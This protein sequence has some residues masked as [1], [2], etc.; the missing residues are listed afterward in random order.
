MLPVM[1]EAIGRSQIF[2]HGVKQGEVRM[3]FPQG[4]GTRG[5]SG[6]V[7]C[8]G[9]QTKKNDLRDCSLPCS[10]GIPVSA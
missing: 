9:L 2:C 1:V 4:N 6:C 10:L 5:S 8:Q 7:K 3:G